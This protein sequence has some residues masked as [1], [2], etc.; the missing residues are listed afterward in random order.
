MTQAETNVTPNWRRTAVNRALAEGPRS[1]KGDP[2]FECQAQ[3]DA[4]FTPA[5]VCWLVNKALYHFEYEATHH[6]KRA[7]ALKAQR[8]ADRQ[9]KA[10]ERSFA[11]PQEQRVASRGTLRFKRGGLES[12]RHEVDADLGPSGEFDEPQVITMETDE[13]EPYQDALDAAFARPQH[14]EGE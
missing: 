1:Q 12:V 5:E 11:E 14:S 13:Q 10:A 3:L 4:F 2:A 7:L 9:A 8:D 6:K